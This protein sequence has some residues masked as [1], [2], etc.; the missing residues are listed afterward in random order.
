MQRVCFPLK[1][2]ADR[3]DEYRQRQAAVWSEMRQA[4]A[5][6]GGRN[7]SPFLREDDLLVGYLEPED[8]DAAREAM[9]ATEVNDRWQAQM[10][11]LFEALDSATPDDAV[12]PLPEVFDLL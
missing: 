9:V 8:V 4:R 10:A 6:T 1:V 7:Y 3:I 5:G 2:P 12:R 11:P